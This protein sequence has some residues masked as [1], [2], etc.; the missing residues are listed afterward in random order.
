MASPSLF[1][2]IF[3]AATLEQAVID[4][5]VK[6]FP[7]YIREIE[8]QEELPM[9]KVPIPRSYTTRRTFEK[10]AEDQLPTVIIVSPGLDGDPMQE[11]DGRY[12]AIWRM[13]VGVVVSTSSQVQTGYIA[14]LMGAAVRAIVLQQSRLGGIASGME[15]YDES[16]DDLPDD[17]VSRSLGA[18]TLSFRIEVDD[19]IN[20]RSGPDTTYIPDPVPDTQ[21]GDTWPQA[22][23]VTVEVIKEAL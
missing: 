14:K 11:G 18:A 9:G 6:W 16:Y 8:R 3:V 1:D 12:R 5:L 7:L 19:V 4:T 2:P 22:E 17:D 23:T 21:P 20:R 10:F 15:W 13:H